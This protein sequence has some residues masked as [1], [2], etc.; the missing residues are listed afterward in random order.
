MINNIE[1]FGCSVTAGNELWEEA[2]VPNYTSL[3]FADARK[4]ATTAPYDELRAYN[5]AHSFPA[6]VAKEMNISFKNHGIP[7]ISNKEIACRAIANF[8]EDNYSGTVVFLQF[9]T[10]N[11][12]FLRYKENAEGSTVGSFVVHAKATDDRLTKSQNNLLKEMYFEF[13]NETML[14][15]DDHVSMY[16]AVEVLRSKGISAHILWCDIDVIDW[17]NWD[18]E[19]GCQIVDKE[20]TIKSDCDPQYM[21]NFSRHIAG[22]H[23]KYN[24]L[25]TTFKSIVGEDAH[26]PRYHYKQRAHYDIA[27]SIV[28]KLKNV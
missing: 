24:L 7:G 3:S 15:H 8:P 23:Y 5:V 2:H 1:F 14:S 11:R 22:S 17:A 27:K 19:K 10:H 13:F 18:P 4:A 28:E 6:L 9:T 21:T 25:G 26:L 12:M 20:V 16:Y